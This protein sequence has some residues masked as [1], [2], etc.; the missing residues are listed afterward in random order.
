MYFDVEQFLHY[1]IANARLLRYPFAHCYIRDV[2]PSD[3]YQKLIA[4]MPDQRFYKRLDET[5]T[6][7]KGAYPERFVCDLVDAQRAE[8]ER[9][10]KP[11]VW[12]DLAK[13]FLGPEF[14]QR[15]LSFFNESV[16]ERFGQDCELDYYLDCRLVRDFSNY[17]ITPHTDAPRKVVS[18]LFYMP[19][20]ESMKELGTSLFVPK[21]PS[22]RCDGNSHHQFRDFKKVMTAAYLP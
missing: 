22:F 16:V 13:V 19:A 1:G 7:P 3:C 8:L 6:V 14:A 18:L 2:F 15:V 11:G 10:G 5:G 4:T 17:A 9:D 20:D 12:D 21:E